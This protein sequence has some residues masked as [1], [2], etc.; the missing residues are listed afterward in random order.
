MCILIDGPD[1]GVQRWDLQL[2]QAIEQYRHT[3][4]CIRGNIVPTQ[5]DK[6]RKVEN[7]LFFT[8]STYGNRDA[9]FGAL[10]RPTGGE[11]KTCLCGRRSHK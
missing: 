4:A 9:Q 5:S 11:T 1:I 3:R 10:L 8:K 2:G 7:G 6:G